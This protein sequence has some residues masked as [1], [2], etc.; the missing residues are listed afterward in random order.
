MYL[1]YF[2]AFAFPRVREPKFEI[3]FRSNNFC[4]LKS[5]GFP[6]ISTKYVI[7]SLLKNNNINRGN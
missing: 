6:L 1:L 7:L 2:M 4:E 5:N 3:S